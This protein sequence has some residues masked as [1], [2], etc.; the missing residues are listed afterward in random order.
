M[1]LYIVCSCE[2]VCI[3]A[4][5]KKSLLPACSERKTKARFLFALLRLLFQLSHS[6]F[7][8]GVAQGVGVSIY[9]NIYETREARHYR[10]TVTE[11]RAEDSYAEEK[12]QAID[13]DDSPARSC[14]YFSQLL[15]YL[16]QKIYR[17]LKK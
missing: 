2:Y 15:F 10:R 12:K 1:P 7:P 8:I 11:R 9:I 14:L 3:H 17:C 4:L 13:L 6:L 16:K 5:Q